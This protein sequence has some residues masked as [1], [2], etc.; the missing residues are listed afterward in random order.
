MAIS[1]NIGYDA[2]GRN[3]DR[4]LTR[5]E[6]VDEKG[7][8][9]IIETVENDL[10]A[11]ELRKR[12]QLESDKEVE[13]T[14]SETILPDTGIVSELKRFIAHMMSGIIFPAKLHV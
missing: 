13:I 5:V 14:F 9:L 10:F 6:T 2:T 12:K 1:E 4:L 11:L 3:S 7:E 8:K